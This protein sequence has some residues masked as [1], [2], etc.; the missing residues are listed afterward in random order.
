MNLRGQKEAVGRSV[1]T[2]K[3]TMGFILD[4]DGPVQVSAL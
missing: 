4:K 3:V 1:G 2:E